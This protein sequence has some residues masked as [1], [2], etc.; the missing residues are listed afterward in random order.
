M[1]LNTETVPKMVRSERYTLQSVPNFLPF[2]PLE[3]S[4]KLR[5]CFRRTLSVRLIWY[6]NFILEQKQKNTLRIFG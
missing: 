6:L 4:R 1:K 3:V 5:F 2:L